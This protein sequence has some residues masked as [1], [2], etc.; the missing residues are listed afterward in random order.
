M[1][2]KP[3]KNH[4]KEEFRPPEDISSHSFDPE[5]DDCF[6]LVNTYGTYNIQPTADTENEFPAIAEG[7]PEF[8][9]RDKRFDPDPPGNARK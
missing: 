4:G 6:N 2:G 8:A 7:M 3:H 1:N 5:P 9:K